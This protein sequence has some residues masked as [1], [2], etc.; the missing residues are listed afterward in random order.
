M[1]EKKVEAKPLSK[2]PFAGFDGDRN[3]VVFQ[4]ECHDGTVQTYSCPPGAVREI[5]ARLLAAQAE[6]AKDA[7]DP[8]TVIVAKTARISFDAKSSHVG[9]T[10][11]PHERSG[12]PFHL[13]PELAQEVSTDLARASA[14]VLPQK[15]GKQN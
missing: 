6:L 13:D 9:L 3:T 1:K 11:Y 10:L 15:P 2:M 5:I 12:I 8:V 4:L 7:G 14:K